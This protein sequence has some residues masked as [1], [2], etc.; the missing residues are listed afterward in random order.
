MSGDNG[1]GLWRAVDDLVDRAPTTADL[2]AHRLYMFAGRRYRNLDRPLPPVLAQIEVLTTARMLALAPFLARIRNATAA[3]LLVLKGPAVA[4]R[5][6]D[7]VLRPFTD[8]DVLV[9]D[10]PATWEELVSDGFFEVGPEEKYLGIHH[11]RPLAFGALPL[12]VELHSAPKWIDG[13]APPT[14]AELF[15]MAVP[16]ALPVEG[17]LALAPGPHALVMAAH[18]WAHAPL[19]RV[20]DLLDVEVLLADT[21]ARADAHRLAGSW[22]MSRVWRTTVE[23]ADAVL[24]GGPV[25]LSLHTWARNV[26]LARDRSV[27]EHHLERWLSGWWE[28]PPQCALRRTAVQI[29]RDLRPNPGEDWR[30]KLGRSARAANRAFVGRAEHDHALRRERS[31][32]RD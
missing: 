21:G 12:V 27:L 20:L 17:F 30:T 25:P 4:S 14:V 29:G 26:R 5:Y 10:A 24:G 8:V 3:P 15:S 32:R 31:R 22:A 1:S 2:I 11:L 28:L 13:A 9:H 19:R 18:A 23:A 7:P 16:A 6:P